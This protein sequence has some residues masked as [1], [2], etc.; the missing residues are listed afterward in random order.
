MQFL[1]QITY[2]S[3]SLFGNKN[4]VAR[5]W[6]TLP[7]M[8]LIKNTLKE[9]RLRLMRGSTN[10]NQTQNASTRNIIPVVFPRMAKYDRSTIDDDHR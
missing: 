4:N 3:I 1:I 9:K 2:F 6:L 5:R 10:L 7:P 8:S